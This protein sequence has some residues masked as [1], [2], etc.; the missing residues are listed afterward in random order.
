ML[1]ALLVLLICLFPALGFAQT[2]PQPISTEVNDLADVLTVQDRSEV[3]EMLRA[4]KTDTGIQMTVLTLESQTPYAPEQ[5]LESFATAVFNNWGVGDSERNDGILVLVLPNDRAMRIELGSGYD[6]SW[7]D[8]AGRVID[9]S[10][11]PSFRSDKYA[12]GIKDGV[13]DTINTLA[14][15]FAK[16]AP[17]PEATKQ[18]PFGFFVFLTAIG[19]FVI[20]RFNKFALR[21]RLCP[22]C[23]ERGSLRLSR[24]VLL[25]PSPMANGSGRKTTYCKQ[26]GYEDHEIYIIPY[27][28]PSRN[29]SSGGGGFGGGRSSGGGASG[30]W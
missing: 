1:R 15:P 6:K 29:R 9:R 7:D 17:A 25:S 4:L 20:S 13:S 30:R 23:Q 27:K 18:P 11:L 21:F 10:F 12:R 5:S 26:C 14:R 19:L 22:N 24:E 28:D 2:L 8:V 16:G 3:R